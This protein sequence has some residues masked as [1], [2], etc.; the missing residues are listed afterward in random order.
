[1]HTAKYPEVEP[2]YKNCHT[3]IHSKPRLIQIRLIRIFANTGWNWRYEWFLTFFFIKIFNLSGFFNPD[4]RLYRIKFALFT[5][6]NP[7]FSARQVI[8]S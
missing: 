3:D 6:R 8:C 4:L 2:S 7:D 1:M 5:S